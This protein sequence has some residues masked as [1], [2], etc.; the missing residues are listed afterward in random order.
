MALEER[1]S[2]LA[3]SLVDILESNDHTRTRVYAAAGGALVTIVMWIVHLTWPEVFAFLFQIESWAKLALGAA[4]APPFVTALAL[5]PFIYRQP[6][7]P[8][9]SEQAG[10]MSTYFYQERSSRRWKLLVVAGIVA[11]LNFLLMLITA[12]M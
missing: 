11:A 2:S 7:E 12:G 4:L 10:P 8:V 6:V 1:A 9:S 3:L 5:G